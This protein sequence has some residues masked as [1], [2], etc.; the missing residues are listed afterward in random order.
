MMVDI[1]IEIDGK[2]VHGYSGESLIS[3]ADR[4]GID[5]PRFCYHKKL[6]VAANCRMCLVDIEGNPTP[7][8][9]CSTLSSAGMK[10]HTKNE[11]AKTAQKAVM[12]FLLINHPLDCPLCDQ[13]GE[14]EL[15]DVAMEYGSDISR[16][17]EGKRI[18]DDKGIGALI[19]TDMTRCIHCT[20]CVRFG[21]E[22]AGIVEM[23]AT[24]RGEDLKIEPFLSEGIQSELSGIMIDVCP[25]GALTSKPFRY[26]VRSWQMNSIQTIARHDLVGSN[27]FTQTHKNKVKRV[28]ARD[29]EN[30]NETWISDRDRFSYQGV[31]NE[32]RVLSPKIKIKGEW[33]DTSWDDAL[34]FATNGIKKHAKEGSQFGTLVSKNATLEELYLLQKFTRGLGSD[35]L[36]YRLDASNPYNAKVLES[37]ISLTELETIDHVL[38][39]NSYLRLEQPMINH[40]IRKATLNGAS[41]STIN[42]KAFDFN[43][44]INHSVLTS[45]Q[46]TVAT[47]SGILKALLDK[48]SQTLPDYLNTVTV[49]QTHIDIANVLLNAKYPVV[50]LG[51]HVNG[52][53]CSDQVAKLVSEIS[54]VSD[55]KTLNASLTGNTRA[56]ERINFKP[57]N[58]KNALQILSSD[59]TA[60]A[61]F[62]V[63]PNFDCIDSE[64]AIKH[65]SR[66]DAFVVAMNSFDDESVLSFANVILP[67]A[68]F[69]ETSGTHINVDNIAQSYSASVKS[70]GESKPGWKV[71]KVLADLMNLQGFDF[72]DSSQIA[73]EALSLTPSTSDIEVPISKSKMP[74]VTT[75]WQYT[76]YASDVVVR[77]AS[78]L[79]Q[80]R[81]GQMSEASVCK[82]TAKLLELSDGDLYKGV[83]VNIN[84]SVA[85]GCVFVHTN[86][87]RQLGVV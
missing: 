14:C 86:L 50:V 51:E 6:S 48:G 33:Q 27:I 18:V 9:A 64:N 26:E 24:G 80:T 49:H 63:Y 53:I 60:F 65:L 87:P 78:S 16:F 20:R 82:A 40:R 52:N 73:D 12:E 54:K 5:I 72:T 37:N 71:I 41:V 30:I 23:G 19:Q 1:E 15:Q 34:D 79:Q 74:N 76:P 25:V 45:P 2:V 55:A 31:N 62:D 75:V 7:Q 10:V 38:I 3:I 32:N 39:V 29:N 57:D 46:N 47:L 13:G 81:I 77:H 68:S 85:E 61:L 11:K 22:V 4:E 69:Y 70:A 56:A 28:V 35:N 36:D 17:T 21:A 58:G 66:D 42:A 8:P 43:Y 84:E 44:R 83:P 67:I 59:L